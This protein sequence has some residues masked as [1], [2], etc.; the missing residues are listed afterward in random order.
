MRFLLASRSPRRQKILK[1]LGFHIQVL[2]SPFAEEVP[3]YHSD[4]ESLAR[5]F[6]EEKML[7]L[8]VS[9]S[10]GMLITA[11]TLVFLGDVIMGKPADMADARRMLLLLSEKTHSVV[12]A[13]CI[14][15]LKTGAAI[16]TSAITR[17]TFDA[18][19]TELLDTYL[20]LGEWRDKAG[21][22]GI[23]GR[24]ALFIKGIEGCYYNVVGFPV[25]LFYR[26][27]Q[28]LGYD[29]HQINLDKY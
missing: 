22:Y 2:Q 21:A 9:E 16:T 10:Q 1:D 8:S 3:R 11:D 23:Q 15:D 4:P 19:S 12:T 17:V 25:N 24:A 7:A 28:H 18:L 6:S 26:S 13:I 27:L 20:S 14:K 5:H 29:P